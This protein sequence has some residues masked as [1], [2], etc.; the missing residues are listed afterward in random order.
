MAYRYFSNKPI[1]AAFEPPFVFTLDGDEAHH[2][3]HV[4]RAKVGEPLVLFDG[5]G[6]EF[7]AEITALRKKEL[8]VA[9]LARRVEDR[10]AP[11]ALTLAVALPKGDRQKWLVEKSVELGAAQ[12][13]PLMAEHSVVK[14]AEATA[15]RLSRS[16]IEASKQ[17]GRNTLMGIGN[18]VTTQALFTRPE[19][20]EGFALKL[21]A[22]PGGLPL[23]E[24]LVPW[25]D[26]GSPGSVIV[27][28]G[29]EGGFSDAEEEMARTGGWTVVS[30]GKRIL[31]TE[32]A[33]IAVTALMLEGR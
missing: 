8:D 20:T 18:A 26:A 17:C 12:L 33:A 21:M 2:I 10:E 11:T 9:L 32:T 24:V 6:A 27:A 29:P 4:M 7:D 5:S 22:R 3:L 25:R 13:W 15:D 23:R 1:P 14:A 30:L 16:V 19:L 28:I 31:R